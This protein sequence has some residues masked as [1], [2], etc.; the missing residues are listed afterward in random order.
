MRKFWLL[1]VVLC[2]CVSAL[3]APAQVDIGSISGTVLDTSDS[4]V[5]GATITAR[6]QGNGTA[7]ETTT[8]GS[9]FFTF[10]NLMV[11]DYTVTAEMNGF[12]TF[13]QT[14]IHLDAADH[15]SVP[16]R[17]SVGEVSQKVEV[18]GAAP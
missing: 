6:N 15:L 8:N 17:L 5:P 3:P 2:I 9:G 13:V 12:K 16:V 10:P 4:V 14:D 18:N 7:K 11:G 1:S